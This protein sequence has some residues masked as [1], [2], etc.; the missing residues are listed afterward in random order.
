VE[1]LRYNGEVPRSGVW[2]RPLLPECASDLAQGDCANE[3]GPLSGGRP[4]GR[5]QRLSRARITTDLIQ[6][7]EP[8]K[9]RLTESAYRSIAREGTERFAL[10]PERAATSALTNSAFS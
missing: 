5:S 10:A 2:P 6:C 7:T 4:L 9:S 1:L 3:L 8:P